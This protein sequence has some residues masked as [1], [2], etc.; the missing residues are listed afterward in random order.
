MSSHSAPG[1]N[2]RVRS[3]VIVEN[4][5]EFNSRRGSMKQLR[6]TDIF[7]MLGTRV[8]TLVDHGNDKPAE[9]ESVSAG[10]E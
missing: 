2:S 6:D 1:M 8:K 9:L 4:V 5:S 3:R 10:E 7:D